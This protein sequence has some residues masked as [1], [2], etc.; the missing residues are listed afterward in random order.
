MTKTTTETICREMNDVRW[1]MNNDVGGLVDSVK[2]L[3][4]WKYYVARYPWICLAGAA[5]IGFAVI[6]KRPKKVYLGADAVEELAKQDGKVR[7]ELQQSSGTKRKATSGL[8]S[9][10][11]NAVI[12]TGMSYLGQNAGSLMGQFTK[13]QEQSHEES[14]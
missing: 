3:G 8:I 7:V 1:Q 14:A 2:T 5:A 10:V 6:P 4:D 13:N 12:R 11:A 9:F